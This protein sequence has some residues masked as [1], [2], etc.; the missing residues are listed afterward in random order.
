MDDPRPEVSHPLPAYN[1]VRQLRTDAWKSL[2]DATDRLG[3]AATR[4]AER[5]RLAQQ[6]EDL[7]GLVT[8]VERYWAYPRCTNGWCCASWS[9]RAITTSLASSTA[10]I[11]RSLAG[12]RTPP[13][14]PPQGTTSTASDRA[15]GQTA[16]PT[17]EVL[18]VDDMS[19]PRRSR[20]GRAATATRPEDQ[21]IYELVVVPSFQDALIAVLLNFNLQA[22][23][24]RHGFR[25]ASRHE[26]GAGRHFFSSI[27]PDKVGLLPVSQRIMLLGE[28]IA[29]LRPELDLY[30]VTQMSVE[31]IAGKLSRN[32]NRVF[33]PGRR[34]RAAFLDPAGGRGA[35]PDAVLH[36]AARLQ[37]AAD[38]RL[39]RAADLARQV[40]PEVPLDPGHDPVLRARHVPR[41]DLGDVR[42]PRLAARAAGPIKRA[43]ELAARAF[44]AKRTFLVT[45]GTS[46]ANK[47]VVQA[48]SAWRHRAGRPQLPQVAPLRARAV[49]RARR[50]S[51]RVSAAT[52]TRCTARCR[53][54]RSSAAAGL[55]AGR[56]ARPREAGA[57]D[58]LHVRRHR[59]RRRA[60]D[61]GMPC[62]QA[63]PDLPVGRGM[64]RV[65]AAFIPPIADAPPW[66]R[67][68]RLRDRFR[69]P[70]YRQ[71][72]AA[73]KADLAGA[74]RTTKRCS[75]RLVPDPDRCASAS[76]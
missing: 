64:V 32:F 41:G 76:T 25:G 17:F 40:D 9:P 63:G 22:C 35:L 59:L 58:Q 26:L 6:A 46:T 7:L 38:G 68:R 29:G 49:R 23:V 61:G 5:A 21:F 14:C 31:D 53:W 60:R 8:P 74:G 28:R 66:P 10:G 20:C 18:V 69:D 11:V 13:A 47:I 15:A 70:E 50:L 73:F 62:D 4:E 57:A 51:R 30:M 37:P 44:G 42:R 52:S 3:K 2:Q 12:T 71:R 67:R 16:Q 45:N 55:T 48:I 75:T 43:Q 19:P 1:S 34:P 72:Y 65:R 24:I 33:P 54:S 39:P 56:Q 36:R 27:A